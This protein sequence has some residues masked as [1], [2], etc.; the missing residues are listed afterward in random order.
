MGSTPSG[1]SYCSGVLCQNYGVCVQDIDGYHCLCMIGFIG[2]HCETGLG[3]VVLIIEGI[4]LMAF[5]ICM[6]RGAMIQR[7]L[8]KT[9]GTDPASGKLFSLVHLPTTGS[10]TIYIHNKNILRMT[11]ISEIL[12]RFDN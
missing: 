12:H 9:K 2:D 3:F 4:V 6:C 1:I 10:S 5:Y 8:D 7:K 11:E